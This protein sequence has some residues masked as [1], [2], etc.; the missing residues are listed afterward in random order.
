MM[1]APKSHFRAHL[2][3]ARSVL[4]AA[5]LAALPA[6]AFAAAPTGATADPSFQSELLRPGNS[7]LRAF[8]YYRGN[9][10]MWTAEGRLTPAAQAVIRMIQTADV[11]GLRPADVHAEELDQAV[12][13][14]NE[15]P[16]REA[17]D[18]AELALS[19]SFADFVIR[20]RRAPDGAMLYEH[21]SLQPQPL[22]VQ[23]VLHDAAAAPSLLDYVQKMAWLHPLYAPVRQAF[24]D[25]QHEDLATRRLVVTNLARIRAIPAA[26]PGGRYVLVNAAAARLWMYENGRPVDTMKVVVGKVDHQTPVMSGYIRY[27]IV[28]PYWNVPADFTRDKIAKAVLQRGKSYLRSAGYQVMSDWTNDATV[29]EPGSVD[30]KAVA[31]GDVNLR[32]RQLP[33][34]GNSMGQVKFEFPNALG[35]YLHDTPQH[36]LMSEQARQFSSGCVRLEDAQRLGKWL[37]GGSMP[38]GEATEERIDLPA[39]V[40]VYITYLTVQPGEDGHL[41]VLDD[42]YG[43]D[44]GGQRSLQ[45][46]LR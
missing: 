40:P 24:L 3:G 29:V 6:A 42:P 45:A 30:W 16:S 5:C 34:A 33:G 31:D 36:Q 18:R 46:A 2:H 44:S 27:A 20:T 22:P 39:V 32:V 15:G 28:N 8:Y 17:A 4:A 43:R 23:G 37:F 14:L 25:G 26:P 7:D 10:P 1:R 11:D 9:Q 19:R 38:G 13:R 12:Q 21:V 41:A 35:I